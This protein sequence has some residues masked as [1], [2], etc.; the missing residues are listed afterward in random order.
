[1]IFSLNKRSQ[2]FLVDI[3]FYFYLENNENVSP[4]VLYFAFGGFNRTTRTT[5]RS[6]P[7]IDRNDNVPFSI[8]LTKQV[9]STN[10]L[11]ALIGSSDLVTLA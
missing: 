10:F 4:F 5:P 2:L 6:A 7:A 11:C 9:D 1:M 8:K 3:I